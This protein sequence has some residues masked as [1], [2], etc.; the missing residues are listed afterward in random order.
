MPG[1]QLHNFEGIITYHRNTP[2]R[3]LGGTLPFLAERLSVVPKEIEQIVF[4]QHHPYR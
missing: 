1:A 3:N 4:L 2:Y